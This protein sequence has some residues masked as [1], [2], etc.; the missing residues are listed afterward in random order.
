MP[1]STFKR[2]ILPILVL[3]AFGAAIYAS[4]DWAVGAAI[5]NRKS[6]LVPNITN[7]SVL[8]ALSLMEQLHLGL[9]KGGEQFDKQSPA[10]TIIRQEPAPGMMVREGRLIRIT[11]S[12]GGETLFVPD[13]VSQPLRNAQT[14]LQNIGLGIGEIDHR[15]SLR[16]EKDIVMAT[17]PPAGSVVA[18]NALVNVILSEGPPT[19]DVLL[20]PDFVGKNISDAKAWAA[21]H[22]VTVSVREENDITRGQGEVLM[23][24]PVADSPLRSGDTL[25]LVSNSGSLTPQG[26]HVHF[27]VPQGSNDVDVKVMVVDESG[28]HEIFRGAKS[29]GSKIDVNVTPKGHARARVIVNGIMVQEQEVQ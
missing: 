9:L 2:R 7:K 21:Q 5:H 6:V 22:Q 28:E 14:N 13:L 24:S 23:Q 17:D 16:F 26:P 15:P 20:S 27:D 19:A 29:P 18:K 1:E 10:G 4:F 8:D 11:L 3:L 12:Q 25:T